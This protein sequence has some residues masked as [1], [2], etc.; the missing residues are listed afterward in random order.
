MNKLLCE[1]IVNAMNATNVTYCAK[2]TI[3]M[4][5]KVTSNISFK[6]I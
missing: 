5:K 1:R 4:N 2:E 3:L 6:S